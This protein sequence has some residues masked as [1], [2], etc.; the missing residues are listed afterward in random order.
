MAALADKIIVVSGGTQ[1]VGAGIARAAAREGATVAALTEAARPR[2]TTGPAERRRQAVVRS[3]GQKRL[4]AALPEERRARVEELLDEL[5][6][7]LHPGEA[8]A[9]KGRGKRAR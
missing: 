1:G 3:L 7:L 5:D 6:R 4:L 9:G 2:L 8:P